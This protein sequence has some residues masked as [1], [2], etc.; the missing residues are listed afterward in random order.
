MRTVPS[1]PCGGRVR[2]NGESLRISAEALKAMR[3]LY[4]DP[5]AQFK[6]QEQA[7]AVRLAM[8]RSEDVLVILP[9]GGGKSV[10]FMAP[11][12]AEK[13]LTTVVIVPFVAL[14]EEMRQRC[15]ELG[16]SCYIWRNSGTILPQ[17]M[18]QVVL[19]GVENAVTPEFQQFLIR[20]EQA[21]KLARIV[22]DECHTVL[23]Q[24]E[25]RKV[26]RRL[27]GTIRCVE[28][29]LVLLTATLPVEM[30]G[31]LQSI[32]GCERITVV[33]QKG[34]R[35]ELRYRVLRPLMERNGKKDLDLEVAKILR[36]KLAE[37]GEN[38][39]AIVYCLKRKWAE[40]LTK[41]L[42]EE[43]KEDVCGTYHADME[44]EERQEIYKRW[45]EGDIVCV[46]AT[47]ALGAGID[48][49]GVRLV[50]HH[51]HGRSMIDL[52]QEMGRGGRDGHMAECLTIFWPGIMEETEWLKEDERKE[53]ME[54]IENLGCRRLAIGLYLN[55]SGVDCLSLKG[56]EWC[57]RCDDACGSVEGLSMS[58]RPRMSG[59][60]NAGA[61][62]ESKEVR[63]GSDLREMI[64]E[65]R[66]RC[67]VCYLSGRKGDDKHELHKC[68]YV[69]DDEING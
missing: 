68:R 28:V 6:S 62:L 69:S 3:G 30:E 43:L 23:T 5:K 56:A 18:A 19:V 1:V 32:L 29:Q 47:S 58:I 44:L 9:T 31:R 2:D 12:W 27:A 15:V 35:L 20:L 26:M 24:R 40:D 54:W 46:V 60:K 39:R 63:N 64:K 36:S 8:Q 41:L 17:R 7:E 13:G 25:F 16:L 48:H 21:E 22:I 49:S 67:I 4:D 34:E 52:C 33:R 37:F 10:V 65:V 51:G 38:D 57:D 53:V 59:R 45:S 42:N 61:L 14:I 11:A 50:I 66:G 55:G